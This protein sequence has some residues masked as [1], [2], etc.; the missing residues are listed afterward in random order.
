MRVFPFLMIVG[1]LGLLSAGCEPTAK[2]TVRTVDDS[3]RPVPDVAITMSFEHN[4]NPNRRTRIRGVTDTN[5]EFTGMSKTS[6]HVNFGARKTGFYT[7]IGEPFEGGQEQNGRW[8]PWN[9]TISLIMRQILNP[10][11][12]L[13]RQA[14]VRTTNYVGT[15]S[16]DLLVGDWTPPFGNGT[17]AD[18]TFTW[19]GSFECPTNAYGVLKFEE[20]RSRATLDLTFQ[21]P[22]DGVLEQ[23]YSIGGSELRMPHQAPLNGYA[24]IRQWRSIF[25]PR[26]RVPGDPDPYRS[27]AYFFRVRTQTNAEGQIVHALYGKT[28]DDVKFYGANRDGTGLEFSYYLNP[29]PNNRNLEFDRKTNLFPL[30]DNPNSKR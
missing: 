4:R 20:I 1:F 30:R 21:N 13:V 23:P 24:P 3:Q 11:P 14:Q 17:N 19:R 27:T 7:S 2:I 28:D 15:A 8:K 16:Y 6:G 25:T 26:E 10:I 5:G 18:L 12:L 29:E 22:G 9:P